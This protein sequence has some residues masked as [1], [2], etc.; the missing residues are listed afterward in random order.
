MDHALKQG[1]EVSPEYDPM[2]A[3]MIACGADREQARR[4]L[5]TALRDTV[6]LGLTTNLSYLIGLLESREFV[7][8]QISTDRLP[9]VPSEEL[10]LAVW[11]AAMAAQGT[12]KGASSPWSSLGRWRI[13]E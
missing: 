9:E 10:P 5:V 6:L 4:R 8:G 7:T 3:K 13:G 11:A 1:C 12:K 2:V